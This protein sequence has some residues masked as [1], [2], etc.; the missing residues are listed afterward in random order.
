LGDDIIRTAPIQD[1]YLPHNDAKK[2]GPAH[3]CLQL[4]ARTLRFQAKS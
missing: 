2:G 3:N 1:Q 4:T